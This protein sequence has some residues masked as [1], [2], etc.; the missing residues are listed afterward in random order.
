MSKYLT[1]HGTRRTP[2][3]RAMR[4]DQKLNEAGGYVWEI[5]KW[6]R[7]RRFLILGTEG[8]SYY[9]S[10]F[11]MTEDAARNV[12]DCIAEDGKRTVNEIVEISKAGR[13][14]KND[15]ALFA[16]AC[17]ISAGDKATRS[18]A[19]EALPAV[20][21]IGTHL[22]HFV[23]Y[24]E[25]MRGW[26]RTMRWAVSNWY[27]R[28]PEQLA[29]QAVKYRQRDGWSHRDLLRLAHP[30]NDQNA[31]IFQWITHGTENLTAAPDVL[32][33]GFEAAQK[34]AS[35]KET[36]DLVRNF[37]LPREAL[38]TEHLNSKEVW[39][40]LLETGMPMHA[41]L[42]NL[43]TMT[44]NGI[45]ESRDH[46]VLVLD[47]LDNQEA[48]TK[49]RLHP[50]AILI[51]M[52]TYAQGHGVRGGNTWMPI[53]AIVD[54]L[55]GAFY[56]A[57]GNVQPTGKRLLVGVDASGSMRS[58]QVAGAPGM[59][60]VKAS[61]AMA[62]VINSTER[63]VETVLFDTTLSMLPLSARQRLDDVMARH[64][65]H[66]RGTDVSLP[67][68]YAIEYKKDFDGI[69][70]LTD[71]QTWAGY[72][73]PAQALTALR[74]QSGIPTRLASIAMVANVHSVNDPKDALSFEAVGFD[75]ATPSLV[76][77]FIAGEF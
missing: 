7:L 36:A 57:F 50:M 8:G 10:E 26:G 44:R 52:T 17:A 61:M 18:A 59:T 64:P 63:D 28:N 1:Q 56:K 42:R 76:S 5:D 51:G 38:L 71:M 4:A 66:G 13:A 12:R 72:Q 43:A 69:I 39:A 6:A 47:A 34:S 31:A 16:L 33:A 24:A 2:Q 55:D 40:A 70:L 30:K 35:P 25:T 3:N 37:N 15:P 14:P 65:G 68:Q 58:G 45:L 75:T 46:R 67:A 41:M 54:A 77:G 62:L 49:S 29:L 32:I 21:R 20:A 23:A 27:D 53:A 60:P 9:A 19:A 48:I 73:H 11:K 22:Y 74:Q